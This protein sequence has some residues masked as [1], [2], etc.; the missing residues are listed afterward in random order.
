MEKQVIFKQRVAGHGEVFTSP[1]EVN[2]MLDLVRV[3]MTVTFKVTVI[4][5]EPYALCP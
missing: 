5:G 4:S 1:R 3:E 2:A